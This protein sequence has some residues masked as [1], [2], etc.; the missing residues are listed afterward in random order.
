LVHAALELPLTKQQPTQHVEK[1]S[2]AERHNEAETPNEAL[3]L[4]TSTATNSTVANVDSSLT[5]T[6]M[7]ASIN[8]DKQLNAID[9]V[10]EPPPNPPVVTQSTVTQTNNKENTQTKQKVIK[11][12]EIRPNPVQNQPNNQTAT[13]NNNNNNNNNN[14]KPAS[15][16]LPK[17]KKK[18]KQKEQPASV[19]SNLES[20]QS[21]VNGQVPQKVPKAKANAN[22]KQ[23]VVTS[24]PIPT[25]P[26]SNQH[27]NFEIGNN[28]VA[29]DS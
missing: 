14:N 8:R 17:M 13:V 18:E 26:V 25:P 6:A 29:I 20:N 1:E 15:N 3:N 5:I 12:V 9:N 28:F 2:A 19:Q 7:V 24:S 22:K 16:T 4:N 23:K 27:S 21:D 11:P 10:I